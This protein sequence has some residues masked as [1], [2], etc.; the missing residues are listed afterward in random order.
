[1][2][3][4]GIDV[5]GTKTVCLLG[6]DDGR[7]VA[8][9]RAGGAN[10]QAVGELELEKVLH[11]LMEQTIR[12]GH[13]PS[14]P[15]AI[16]LG[17]A[18][19]DRA[20][21]T[22]LVRAVMS[23]IGYGARI[24]V[25]NDALI[26]LQAAVGDAPGIVIV[27]GTGSIAYGRHR[28]GRAARAGGWGPVLDDEGSGYWIGRRALRAVMREADGRGEPTSLT[29]RVLRYYGIKR[30][31]ELVRVVCQ[32]ELKA[33]KIASLARLVQLAFDDGDRAAAD[34]LNRSAERLM[35]AA[36]AV[37]EQLEMAD[38]QFMFVLAGGTFQAVPWLRKQLSRTLATVAPRSSTMQLEKEP[39]FGAV[40]LALA[41]AR[42]KAKVPVYKRRR[43]S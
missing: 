23:R 14:L 28:D 8:S 27:A 20:E 25:V 10:L 21:D 17:M 3:V 4:L 5:G 6:D 32:R 30:A 36:A 33:S 15:S 1:M 39:A 11:G 31:E 43:R 12:S 18:G 37:T 35:A 2:H 26:A 19:V 41:E 13:L 42:G 29:E 40:Q 24:L 7:I 16:C 34:I 22:D 9:A 38:E